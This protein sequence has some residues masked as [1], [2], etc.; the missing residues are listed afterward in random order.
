MSD[1]PRTDA[2]QATD[3]GDTKPVFEFARQLE[4][5]L[6]A[7]QDKLAELQADAARLDW[8]ERSRADLAS[9]KVNRWVLVFGDANVCQGMTARDAIDAAMKDTQ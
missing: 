4:R 6:N 5:E 9:V 1:T 7:A 3:N 8:L 2:E